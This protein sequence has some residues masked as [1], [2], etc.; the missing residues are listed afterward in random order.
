M[1]LLVQHLTIDKRQYLT[2]TPISGQSLSR[3][4]QIL[5]PFLSTFPSFFN[6]FLSCNFV[7]S[8]TTCADKGV[9]IV[10]FRDKGNMGRWPC[11]T[12]KDIC[13][14]QLPNSALPPVLN[15]YP[16]KHSCSQKLRAGIWKHLMC[17]TIPQKLYYS[18][19]VLL[20]E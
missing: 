4:S 2:I 16:H 1:I 19:L 20:C 13:Y 9:E 14:L 15:M 8:N 3:F 10:I 12:R 6:Q 18:W 5:W 17:Q 7:Q 11:F